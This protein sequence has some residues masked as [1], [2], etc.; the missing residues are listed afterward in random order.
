MK[1][2]ILI[3]VLVLSGGVAYAEWVLIAKSKTQDGMT[4]YADPHTIQR[5]G[6]LVKMWVLF[7]FETAQQGAGGPFLSMRILR[8]FNCSEERTRLLLTT[9][10]SDNMG[11]GDITFYNDDRQ[12]WQPIPPGSSFHAL[13]ASACRME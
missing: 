13:W 12:K 7:D 2:L 1:H 4:T 8:Q 9:W 11:A 10:F 6:E 3:V 5:K